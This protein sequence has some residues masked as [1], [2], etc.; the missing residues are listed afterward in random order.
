MAGLIAG[1][2]AVIYYRAMLR[3]SLRGDVT[4]VQLVMK[5]L[6]LYAAVLIVTF[7]VATPKAASAR[8]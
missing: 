2:V 1:V 7:G 3:Y 4:S 6:V 8:R 5:N